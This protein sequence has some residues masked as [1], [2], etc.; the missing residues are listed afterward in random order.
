MNRDRWVQVRG[1]VDEF[2]FLGVLGNEGKGFR[3]FYK[4]YES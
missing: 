3:F 2:I 4:F 1:G